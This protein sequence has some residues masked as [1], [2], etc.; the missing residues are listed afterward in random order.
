MRALLLELRPTTLEEKGLVPA[1]EEL[2]STYATRLGIRVQADLEP[3]PMPPASELA[4]LR[5][6]PLVCVCPCSIQGGG[7]PPRVPALP[8]PNPH[9]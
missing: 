5:I 2:V 9:R 6:A 4:A 3:A 8:T 7:A 1:L